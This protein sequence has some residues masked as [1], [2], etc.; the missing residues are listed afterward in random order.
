MKKTIYLVRG[1]KIESY[2][3]FKDRIFKL[4]TFIS[5]VHNPIS[6]KIVLTEE[7]P[8]LISI[9][10]FKKSKIASISIVVEKSNYFE[11]LINEKGFTG[12]YETT[13]ALPVS[14]TKNWVD[15]EITPGVCL[16]TLF[17][18][19]KSIDYKTFINR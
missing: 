6:L 10:P 9:I 15:G 18:Q 5:E 14:Y 3:D 7:V 12:L 1:E 19:K 2:E 8:P 13:E 4:T 16:L 17:N 11:E